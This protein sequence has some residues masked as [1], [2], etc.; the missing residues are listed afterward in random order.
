MRKIISLVL[1]LSLCILLCAC[2]VKRSPSK[3]SQTNYIQNSNSITSDSLSERARK[4]AAQTLGCDESLLLNSENNKTDKTGNYVFELKDEGKMYDEIK[5]CSL[6]YDSSND[7]FSSEVSTKRKLHPTGIW[8]NSLEIINSQDGI[9]NIAHYR[10]GTNSYNVKYNS[11]QI[12]AV[13]ENDNDETVVG[14]SLGDEDSTNSYF[15]YDYYVLE[16]IGS[17]GNLKPLK[18]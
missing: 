17:N 3:E 14:E 6:K 13:E 12:C 4:E 2:G 5:V 1:V 7:D 18:S 15:P 16:A 9:V 11:Y 8:G 10:T